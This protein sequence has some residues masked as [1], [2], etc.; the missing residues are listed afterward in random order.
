LYRQQGKLIEVPGTGTPE[1]VFARIVAVVDN[2]KTQRRAQV[3]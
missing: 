1:Q 2:L 3:R